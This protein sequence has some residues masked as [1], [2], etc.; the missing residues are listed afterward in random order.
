VRAL[1]HG[2]AITGTSTVRALQRHGYEV[3]ATDD[4]VDDDKLDRAS[5]LGVS[6]TALP[7]SVS[8]FVAGFDL[9]SPAPGVPE[10]HPVIV[11]ALASGVPVHSEIELAYRWEQDRPGGPRPILAI[12]GT[13]GKTTTTDLTVAIL[14]AAGMRTAALGNTDVPL[15][16]AI[17]TDLDVL[18]VECTS[19]RLAWTE[20]FRAD[21]A[22]WL[23][24][25]P[26]HLNWHESMQTY[27][28]AKARIFEL[29]APGDTAVGLIDDPAVM[30]HLDRAPGRRRTFGL[31]GA[32]YRLEGDLLIGPDGP[33]VATSAMRRCLPHDIT[34]A[35]AASAL[36]LES[37][38]AT[39]AAIAE[40]LATFVAPPHRLE[41]IG[42]RDGIDWFNDSKATTPHAASTAIRAFSSLVLIAGG[43]RKGVDLSPM[44]AEPHRLRGVVAI[45][46]AADDIHAIFDGTTTVVDAANMAEAV[47]QAAR[48][49]R[50]G[51]AV[52]LSPGCASFDWYQGYPAR[53][54]DFRSLVRDYLGATSQMETT[55]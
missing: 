7:D 28:A 4:V 43:S 35:L 25:A 27:E 33:I 46:E 19:F 41:P 44:A 54:D 15:V 55:T 3:V 20:R 32:D 45:G 18:V 29:Q 22:V 12:T 48:L 24:L 10:R 50:H 23:N 37:G 52:V 9:L 11:A 49:A 38:L 8:Q 26:D 51:D 17:D 21:A 34:N 14:R 53:G 40:A 47:E 1:V 5:E 31:S 16:D 39:P 13:D 6:L 2:L 36:V 42:S 30:S